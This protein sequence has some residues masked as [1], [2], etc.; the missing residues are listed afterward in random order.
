MARNKVMKL[1]TAVVTVF[2]A[3]CAALGFSTTTAAAAPQPQPAHDTGAHVTL[4]RQAHGNRAADRSLPPTLKQRI[5]AEAHGSSPACRHR[6]LTAT[7][8]MTAITHC[9]ER[10]RVAPTAFHDP[11]VRLRR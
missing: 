8:P 7:T 3:L 6:K 2:L 10:A 9:A 11:T 5:R 1:W 4:P